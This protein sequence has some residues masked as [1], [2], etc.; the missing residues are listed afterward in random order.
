MNALAIIAQARAAGLTLALDLPDK[1]RVR[2]AAAAR[3]RLLPLLREHKAELLELLAANDPAAEPLPVDDIPRRRWRVTLPNGE[4]LDV[5]YCPAVT[6][7]EV[8]AWWPAGSALAAVPEDLLPASGPEL[9]AHQEAKIKAWLRHI[10]EQDPAT[11]GEV[12]TKCRHDPAARE[13]FL[14]RAAEVPERSPGPVFCETCRHAQATDHPFLVSCRVGAP[15]SN[16]TG[17]FWKTDPR[18]CAQWDATV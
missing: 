7:A 14:R 10:D 18:G 2:G 9:L 1:I 3:N 17:R 16:P 15:C 13:Y 11:I 5:T 12:L 4:A 8:A 6:A